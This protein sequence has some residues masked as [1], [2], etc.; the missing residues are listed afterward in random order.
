MQEIK[1][2]LCCIKVSATRLF[3]PICAD[4]IVT[5]K[6][7]VNAKA[8]VISMESFQNRFQWNDWFCNDEYFGRLNLGL[9]EFDD[10][11]MSECFKLL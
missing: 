3:A 4:S 6:E 10:S 8:N 11:R 5:Y 1:C 7:T 2:F 9:N